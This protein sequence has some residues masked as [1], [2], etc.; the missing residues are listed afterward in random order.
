MT[1]EEADRQ[2]MEIR[3][4]VEWLA[5][6]VRDGTDPIRRLVMTLPDYPWKVE[7]RPGRTHPSDP[8]DWDLFV[9]G[10]PCGGTLT[11]DDGGVCFWGGE[12]RQGVAPSLESAKA[13]LLDRVQFDL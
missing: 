13:A 6:A 12:K 1:Q 5:D 7:W 8:N 2:A 9:R 4:Y 10:A 11:N 3:D